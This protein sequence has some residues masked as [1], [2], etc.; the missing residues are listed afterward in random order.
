MLGNVTATIFDHLPQFAIISNISGNTA[1]NLI[2]MRDTGANLF[3]K[4]LF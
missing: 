4:I 3:K 2:F 1:S